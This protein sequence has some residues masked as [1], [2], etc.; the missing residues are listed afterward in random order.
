MD[1]RRGFWEGLAKSAGSEVALTSSDS[2]L[3]KVGALCGYTMLQLKRS[4]SL[5]S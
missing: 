2:S 3:V 5:K 4:A 1:S